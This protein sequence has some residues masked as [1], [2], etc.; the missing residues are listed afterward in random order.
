[1]NQVVE[2]FN[3]MKVLFWHLIRLSSMYYRGENIVAGSS[4]GEKLSALDTLRKLKEKT[5][6]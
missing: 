4:W 3:K 5:F 2:F 6:S 1:M